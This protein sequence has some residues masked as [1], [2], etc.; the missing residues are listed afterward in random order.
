[1]TDRVQGQLMTY[2]HR[3]ALDMFL[4]KDVKRGTVNINLN[5]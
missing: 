5:Y 1:M 2:Q 4:A 3:M